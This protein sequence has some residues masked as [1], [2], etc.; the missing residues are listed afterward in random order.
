MAATWPTGFSATPT[1]SSASSR[2]TACSTP[3]PPG[4]RLKNSGS[5]SGSTRDAIRQPR[6]VSKVVAAPVREEFQNADLGR[7]R[8][9]RLSPRRQRR[10]PVVHHAAAAGRA[11]EDALLPRRRPLGAETAKFAALVQDG[12]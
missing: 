12:E 6:D 11:V 9:T 8:A 2:T 1:A 7:A 3:N 4:G 5:T 10:V